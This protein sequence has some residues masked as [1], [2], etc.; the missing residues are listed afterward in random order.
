MAGHAAIQSQNSRTGRKVSFQEVHG[1][2]PSARCSV[3][4]KDGFFCTAGALVSRPLEATRARRG[5]GG[6]ASGHWLVQLCLPASS[7]EGAPVRRSRLQRTSVDA[8]NV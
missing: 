7:R 1:A 5:A 3:Q 6:T 2:V 4:T 8:A